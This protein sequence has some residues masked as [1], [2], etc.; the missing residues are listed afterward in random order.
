MKSPETAHPPAPK[1]STVATTQPRR[2]TTP[3][4]EH[5]LSHVPLQPAPRAL[6]TDGAKEKH[7][8]RSAPTV[9]TVDRISPLIL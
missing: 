9:A 8:R 1:P 5:G 2:R 7:P 6:A 3:P 4:A